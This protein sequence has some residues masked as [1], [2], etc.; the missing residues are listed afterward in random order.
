MPFAAHA[1]RTAEPCRWPAVES[2][3][4]NLR[5]ARH[6]VDEARH[7]AEDAIGDATM[8]IRRHPLRSIGAAVVAGA[9]A[10][11]L[12]GFGAGWFAGRRAC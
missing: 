9:I 1:E 2:V 8:K 3:G 10:G 5:Q 4:E 12:V 7:A 11:A 6:A